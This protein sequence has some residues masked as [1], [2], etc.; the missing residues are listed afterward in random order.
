MFSNRFSVISLFVLIIIA[1]ASA[2]CSADCEGLVTADLNGDCKVDFVDLE[3]L[4]ENWLDITCVTPDCQ[5][6]IDG[7]GNV[8]LVD[9]A[10]MVDNWNK[11]PLFINEIL[12]SNSSINHDPQG[13]SD[14]WV[15]IYNPSGDAIDLAGMYLTDDL[16]DPMKW[17][18]P[19]GYP[20]D[21]TIA[22]GGYLLVWADEDAEDGPLHVGFK[23]SADGE[24]VAL[25]DQNVNLI[26][27][28]EFGV[29]NTDISYGCYPDA[30]RGLQFFV[31]PTPAAANNQ[32]GIAGWPEKV[33]FSKDGGVFTGSFQLTMTVD[34]PGA[35]IRY[36]LDYK[37]PSASDTLYTG[38]ITIS[39]STRISARA[40][41]AGL[42][43]GPVA[44]DAFLKLDSSIANFNSNLPIVILDTNGFDIN[45]E[46]DAAL[47]YPYRN[48][49]SVF[50]DVDEITGR[51]HVT[52]K[53]DYAGRGGMKV[54]G[55]TSAT[56]PKKQY[57]FEIW[58][59]ND[60]DKNASIFGMPSDSDWVIHGP[61]LDQTLMR[62][63]LTFK[64]SNEMGEYAPRTVYCEAFLNT[65]GGSVSYSNYVGTY[66]I[67]E[68][69]KRSKDRVDVE[70]L[71][72]TNNTEP[73]VSGGYILAFDKGNFDTPAR[74][75]FNTSVYNKSVQYV[76]PA[77]D[78][79]TAAQKS[80]LSSWFTAFET[81]LKGSSFADPVNG[82][83]KYIDVQSFIDQHLL[84]ELTKNVD[85]YV[86]STFMYK[87]RNGKLT[88][89]PA[90]DYNLSLGNSRSRVGWSSEGWKDFYSQWFVRLFDDPEFRLKHWDR[91][92]EL[93][94]GPLATTKLRD[95]IDDTAAYLNESNARN[96]VKWN[97]LGYALWPNPMAPGTYAAG[98]QW[99]KNW[100]TADI[101]TIGGFTIDNEYIAPY[102]GMGR[103]AWI[104]SQFPNPP[105]FNQQGGE[106][107]K[108]FALTMTPAAT[109]SVYYTTDGSQPNNP[110][111]TSI[112][113]IIPAGA[114][115]KY[116]DNGTNQGT[117]WQAAGF[118]D[119][120]WKSGPSE[121][122]YGEGD[123]ATVLS[124]GTS[125]SNK[126]TTYYF[127]YKFS[128]T[129]AQV[130]S[131]LSLDLWL[132]RDD[133]AVVY[134]N[135]QEVARSN[136]PSGTITYTTFASMAYGADE[137][138]F[139][140]FQL[141]P[142]ILVAGNNCVAVEV[143]QMD[144]TSSDLSF[145]LKLIAGVTSAG[146]TSA[147]AVRYTSPVMLTKS[148]HIKARTLITGGLY[149]WSALNEATFSV[150]PVKESLRVTEL[151]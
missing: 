82:Y 72:P 58:D 138:T 13:D 78:E 89:G 45:S 22:A 8:N 1:I 11:V 21:T 149:P 130:S 150:G 38:P 67:M 126:Y 120:S 129:A 105:V 141:D 85:G 62:N 66:I 76:E 143:H 119:T 117:A 99:M 121:L 132:V 10:I 79:L 46:T 32:Q 17:Q 137:S 43:P 112:M 151:M 144:K 60:E 49:Y 88:M 47:D 63:Y 140:N 39:S 84:V 133:G 92:F 69:I 94:R 124:Y 53:P 107:Q 26:D 136:M 3:V 34:T 25:F 103:V 64:W 2:V 40:F 7:L 97:T 4:A 65:S 9:F 91:W 123:E 81:A 51:A 113:T 146:T 37:D 104:D 73:D 57:N 5:A 108:N 102:Q 75:Y 42:A 29:Q 14:D 83:A 93:R 33:A 30:V 71:D 101:W 114:T 23:L 145:N 110:V 41:A 100:L 139:H 6:D 134:I 74:N 116:L 106:V 80:W 142:G 95:D 24:A 118:N 56:N 86:M 44:K 27:T 96:F 31:T 98:V 68:K 50:I 115:W 20:A 12:A 52:D 111:E 36:R 128:L 61:Y 131:A 59:A 90:W 135:G 147:S 55:Q 54:R 77:Y 70:K 16:S 18:F 125:S 127:R 148:T 122:G 15:E 48:T 87:D 35:S 109:G 28:L 19:S